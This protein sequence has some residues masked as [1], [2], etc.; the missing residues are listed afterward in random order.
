MVFFIS[1]NFPKMFG[2]KFSP[3]W[4]GH[5]STSKAPFEL[6][7]HQST[8]LSERKRSPASRPPTPHWAS[9]R[10]R[11]ACCRQNFIFG[12]C[13]GVLVM[14]SAVFVM[15]VSP[16]ARWI[17]CKG[18]KKGE[19][20]DNAEKNTHGAGPSLSEPPISFSCRSPPQNGRHNFYCT[21]VSLR[22]FLGKTRKTAIVLVLVLSV[23]KI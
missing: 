16:L 22:K 2:P 3:T 17:F 18:G 23:I 13:F 19:K 9:G 7:L 10:C 11:N 21:L 12:P 14:F 6:K 4:S 20:M 8:L 15:C 5:I 1:A